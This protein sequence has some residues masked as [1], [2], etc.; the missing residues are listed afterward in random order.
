[1]FPVP[2][3]PVH[4][5]PAVPSRAARIDAF[6][7]EGE[8]P[9]SM[10]ADGEHRSGRRAEVTRLL[11]GGDASR[12]ALYE[13][14][15]SELRE[16]ADQRMAGERVG[17]TLQATALVHEAWMRLA[18]HQ[19]ADWRDRGHFLAAA[20]EAMRRI[21][22]DHARRAGA[23]KRGGDRDRVTLGS[24]GAELEVDAEEA[25]LLAEALVRLGRSDPAAAE[26]TR[27]RFFAGLSVE[28][29]ARA[30]GITVRTVHREWVYA[31][32]RLFEWVRDH[33]RG[34]AH[35]PRP[36]GEERP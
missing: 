15:Y 5:K 27:L 17:H 30:L 6:R 13:L 22:I 12:E 25:V 20:S 36:D 10:P 9:G 4:W 28:D 26:V 7:P 16:I 23:A 19:N 33:E 1:M 35:G 3:A 21:L 34:S 14:L 2:L 31:R 11:R 32:A 29:T 24:L 18:E 8:D